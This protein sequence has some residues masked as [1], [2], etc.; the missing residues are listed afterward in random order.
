MELNE[1]YENKNFNCYKKFKTEWVIR[2]W[3]HSKYRT[4]MNDNRYFH[5]NVESCIHP[6]S[7]QVKIIEINGLEKVQVV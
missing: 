4:K 7:L 2:D 1:D 6:T 5:Y 3:K